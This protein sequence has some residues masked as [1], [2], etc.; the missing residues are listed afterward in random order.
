MEMMIQEGMENSPKILCL[1]ILQ[2]GVLLNN[3]PIIT[4][5]DSYYFLSLNMKIFRHVFLT[6]NIL[7]FPKAAFEKER[8]KERKKEEKTSSLNILVMIIGFVS[9][10]ECIPIVCICSMKKSTQN[11][12]HCLCQQETESVKSWF[13]RKKEMKSDK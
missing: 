10:V 9:C 5:L 11:I 1:E 2:D 6:I 8:K 4:E 13:T 3:F 7:L 12:L